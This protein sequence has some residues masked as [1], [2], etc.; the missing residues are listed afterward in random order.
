MGELKEFLK[1]RIFYINLGIAIVLLVVVFEG[2]SKFLSWYTRHGEY[3][4]LPDLSKK[5]LTDVQMLLKSKGLKPVVIDS[6][7][8][9]K[10][11]PKT[12]INQV[13]YIG[14]HVKSGRNVYLYITSAV[15]P[16][17][18]IPSSGVVDAPFASAKMILDRDGIKIEGTSYKVDICV[19][20]V[21]SVMYKGK[22]LQPGDK[23]QVGS[24]VSL[25]IGRDA[26]SSPDGE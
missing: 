22:E 12:V 7:Y 17:V 16:M 9:G 26:N 21:L 3:I 2:A 15:A 24:K 10:L 5:S 25:V 4:V 8:D 11:P 18:E 19:G 13:P 20:C 14:A 1:S 23:L 6:S